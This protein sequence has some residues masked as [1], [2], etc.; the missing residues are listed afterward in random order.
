M[1]LRPPFRPRHSLV[2][3]PAGWLTDPRP[4]ERA[5]LEQVASLP[6]LR[7]SFRA[8][9]ELPPRHQSEN[10]PGLHVDPAPLTSRVIRGPWPDPASRYEALLLTLRASRRDAELAAAQRV[11]SDGQSVRRVIVEL[12]AES[13]EVVDARRFPELTNSA[14]L[15]RDKDAWQLLRAIRD[16][17]A[18]AIWIR[19]SSGTEEAVVLFHECIGDTMH[20]RDEAVFEIERHG[21]AR[22]LPLDGSSGHAPP[23]ARGRRGIGTW[24]APLAGA[25]LA[26][27]VGLGAR[28][29]AGIDLALPWALLALAGVVGVIAL[30]RGLARARVVAADRRAAARDALTL[31]ASEYALAI[32][33]LTFQE[34]A[35]VNALA[36]RD[37][38]LSRLGLVDREHGSRR[39]RVLMVV[40]AWTTAA[41]G[42]A[43][44][45]LAVVGDGNVDGIGPAAFVTALVGLALASTVYRGEKRSRFR[46]RALVVVTCVAVLCAIELATRTS[47]GLELVR[48]GALLVIAALALAFALAEPLT[49]GIATCRRVLTHVLELPNSHE[50]IVDRLDELQRGRSSRDHDGP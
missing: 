14:L 10:D 4:L 8:W 30:L 23:A 27:A 5:V 32:H 1:A 47:T 21:N 16:C 48:P 28:Q 36:G 38:T 46:H 22:R 44:V 20:V 49:R 42:G 29:W 15:A 7:V 18:E 50:A 9:D 17:D 39:A 34:R 35:V 33:A 6:R 31:S 45:A 12:D 40:A 19:N 13:I 24:V 26:A 3:P 43:V 41:V 25:V 37:E 11:I 2:E